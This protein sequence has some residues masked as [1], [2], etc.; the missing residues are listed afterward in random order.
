MSLLGSTLVFVFAGQLAAKAKEPPTVQQVRLAVERSL[1]FL[2]EGGEAWREGR[3]GGGQNKRVC[4]TCHQSLYALSVANRTGDPAV[5]RAW[6]YLLDTQQTDG[7][8]KAG[9]RRDAAHV[10]VVTIHWGTGWATIGLIRTLP[11]EN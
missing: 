2:A 1:P 7:S 9:S 11:I 8:W 6:K 3:A 5:P 10:N 4:V